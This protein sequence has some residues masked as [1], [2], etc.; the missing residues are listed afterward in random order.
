MRLGGGGLGGDFTEVRRKNWGEKACM[1]MYEIPKELEYF[2]QTT[3]PHFV[4]SYL[5]SFSQISQGEV[6]KLRLLC[7]SKWQQFSSEWWEEHCHG[8]LTKLG[9]GCGHPLSEITVVTSS[10]HEKK[11]LCECRILTAP[12][13]KLA[14]ILPT[15]P[16][17]CHRFLFL[18][19]ISLDP[20][21][22][23]LVPCV[24][25]YFRQLFT[26][27]TLGSAFISRLQHK[28]PPRRTSWRTVP[29]WCRL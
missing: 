12:S 26:E 27:P 6:Q 14:Q 8:L 18:L 25:G 19:P 5:L 3:I 2:F 28:V 15:Y 11:V 23:S 20:L 9:E 4:L 1:I 17:M 16:L 13:A 22:S 7:T 10:W 29:F 21:M 24:G